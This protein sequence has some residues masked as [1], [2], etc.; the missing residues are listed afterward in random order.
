MQFVT[1][2]PSVPAIGFEKKISIHFRHGCEEKCRC[3][4][5]SSTCGHVITLSVHWDNLEDFSTMM[6]DTFKGC[7]GFGRV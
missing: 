5:V 3:R 4:A 2:S 7:N 6:I 1:G